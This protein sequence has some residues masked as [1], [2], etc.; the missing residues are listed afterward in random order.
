MKIIYLIK[1]YIK[2][3]K[4]WGEKEAKRLFKEFPFYDYNDLI[5][6]PYIKRLNNIDVLREFPFYDELIFVGIAL[7]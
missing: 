5:G 2:K 4:F 6:K 3:L 1:F 7:K